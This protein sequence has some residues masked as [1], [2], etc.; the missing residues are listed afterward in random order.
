MNGVYLDPENFDQRSM[1]GH[2]SGDSMKFYYL[3]LS[4]VDFN[5]MCL[6]PLIPS[7]SCF[8]AL[9]FQAIVLPQHQEIPNE[10][11]GKPFQGALQTYY[12]PDR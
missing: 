6:S 2:S 4:C 5:T 7:Q 11:K 12:P 8:M 1:T 9:L 10:S 3:F